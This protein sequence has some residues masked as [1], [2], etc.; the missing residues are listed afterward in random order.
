MLKNILKEYLLEISDIR[1]F[2]F[3]F[4]NWYYMEKL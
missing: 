1:F 3:I 2:I 4:N